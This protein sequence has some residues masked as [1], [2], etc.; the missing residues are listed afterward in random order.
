MLA[1]KKMALTTFKGDNMQH[2]C[3]VVVGA[4]DGEG[5][6]LDDKFFPMHQEARAKQFAKF[7]KSGFAR[8][9]PGVVYK[10]YLQVN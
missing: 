5:C 6:L 3:F 2:Y 4:R 10:L 1:I 8:T 9:A 7:Y